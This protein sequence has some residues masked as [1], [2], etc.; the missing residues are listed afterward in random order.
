MNEWCFIPLLQN[1]GASDELL[2]EVPTEPKRLQA[3]FAEEP[4]QSR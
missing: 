2:N 3:F 4:S 1:F